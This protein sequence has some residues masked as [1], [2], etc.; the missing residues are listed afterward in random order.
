LEHR[1]FAEIN[2]SNDRRSERVLG[3]FSPARR[4]SRA[5][6]FLVEECVDSVMAI[7]DPMQLALGAFGTRR[8]LS[9]AVRVWLDDH[10]SDFK[11]V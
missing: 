3:E 9:V 5:P 7:G 6:A 11:F 10:A 8:A 1:H 4:G 2:K